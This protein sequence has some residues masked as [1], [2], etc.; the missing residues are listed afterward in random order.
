[1]CIRDSFYPSKDQGLSEIKETGLKFKH[2]LEENETGG[3]LQPATSADL[4]RAG[5]LSDDDNEGDLEKQTS[6]SDQKR[7]SSSSGKV[8]SNVEEPNF[9]PEDEEFHKFSYGDVEGLDTNENAHKSVD[10]NGAVVIN[11]DAGNVF[12]DANAVTQDPKAFP[13]NQT[14][15]MSWKDKVTSFFMPYK[16][17]EFSAVR[18]SLPHVYN[19]AIEY[20]KGYTETAYTDPSVTEPEP[21]LWI[22]KDPFGLSTQQ[23]LLAQTNG[24][25]VSDEFT[26][27]DEKS[28]STF[29]FNPPDFE[30][31]AKR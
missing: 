10:A 30:P 19:A 17:Y 15:N 31:E 13:P 3:V 9:V 14:A 20:K 16:R 24:V 23:I 1:M 5:I 4:K 11:A 2:D 29:S 12:S 18:R 28:R 21:I 6:D 26:G 22:A 25:K 27:Y 8:G 7:H